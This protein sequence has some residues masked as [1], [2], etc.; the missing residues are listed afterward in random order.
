[1]KKVTV[2]LTAI[3]LLATITTPCFAEIIINAADAGDG[4]LRIGYTATEGEQPVGFALTVDVSGSYIEG[5]QDLVSY[6]PE[7]GIF[8]DYWGNPPEGYHPFAQPNQPGPVDFPAS[9]FSV[10]MVGLFNPGT[11]VPES[12]SDLITIQLH[13]DTPEFVQV[14]IAPDTFRGGVVALGGAALDATMPQ[15]FQIYV[16]EPTTLLLLGL[17]GLMLRRHRRRS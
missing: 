14:T 15:P 7:F 2:L 17:G 16:P 1:M 10:S 13:S 12:I 3:S 4:Q 5:P 8:L 9:Y 6:A 11:S